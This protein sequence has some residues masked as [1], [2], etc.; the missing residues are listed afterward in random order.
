[1]TDTPRLETKET[2]RRDTK[3]AFARAFQPG[4]GG[5]EWHTT[6]YRVAVG[7]QHGPWRVALNKSL[8][9]DAKRLTGRA[10][11]VEQLA[12]LERVKT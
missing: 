4:F 11:T 1:M 6:S 7:D 10:W 8:L 12:E 3:S 9:A 2:K 5:V